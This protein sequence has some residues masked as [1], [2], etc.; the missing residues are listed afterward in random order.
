MSRLIMDSVKE[1]SCLLPSLFFIAPS[2][3]FIGILLLVSGIS[4]YNPRPVI[5]N[6]GDSNS[7]TGTYFIMHGKIA[8]LPQSVIQ[9]LSLQFQGRMSDGRL[10]LDFLCESLNAS[11][12]SP[13]VESVGANFTNGVNFA[14]S[15]SSII[16]TSDFF[17]LQNQVAHFGRFKRRSLDF[18]YEEDKDL[19][20]NEE[21]ENGL[22]L[23]DIGQNDLATVF[24][25]HTY[26][27][28]VKRISTLISEIENSMWVLYQQGAR[29]FWV[30]NT[31]PLGCLPEILA[32]RKYSASELD[33]YGCVVTVNKGARVFNDELLRLCN[34][35]TRVMKDAVIVYVDVHNIKYDLIANPSTFGFE[36][37]ITACCGYGGGQY[38][39]NYTTLCGVPG[40]EVCEKRSEHVNWDGFHYTEAANKFVATQILSTRYSSPQLALA[41]VLLSSIAAPAPEPA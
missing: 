27:E 7:D 32:S 5:F 2:L 33:Q 22:Y 34:K 21:F 39:F 23:I 18:F 9:S 25:I 24:G 6:F 13:F 41:D 8:Q 3:V 1:R 11:Y 35:L 15:G 31:G 28:V 20:G 37:A 17:S 12:L 40:F 26:D 36:N 10:I 38:N 4:G 16:P 29:K 30:H 19:L 14:M